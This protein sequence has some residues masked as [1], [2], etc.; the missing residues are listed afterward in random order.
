MRRKK[1]IRDYPAFVLRRHRT[2]GIDDHDQSYHIN[3]AKL[4]GAGRF[5]A[6][7]MVIDSWKKDVKD[8]DEERLKKLRERS[9]VSQGR[10]DYD[11]EGN[12]QSGDLDRRR[13]FDGVNYVQRDLPYHVYKK[14]AKEEADGYRFFGIDAK[15]VPK[16]EKGRTIYAVFVPEKDVDWINKNMVKNLHVMKLQSGDLGRGVHIAPTEEGKFSLDIFSLRRHKDTSIGKRQIFDDIDDAIKQARRTVKRSDKGGYIEIFSET[17][18]EVAR[19]VQSEFYDTTGKVVGKKIDI[20]KLSGDLRL[21]SVSTTTAESIADDNSLQVCV[22]EG[23]SVVRIVKRRNLK[24]LTNFV[25]IT[26]E[27]AHEILDKSGA[28]FYSDGSFLKIMKKG[29]GIRKRSEW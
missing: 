28:Q 17:G 24:K 1:R 9:F 13:K 26:W 29:R 19:V 12:L 11:R 18:D 22:V 7:K 6:D 21:K 23:T 14:D 5:R 3:V 4:Y 10:M 8:I 20:R 25:P 27:E 15:V 2:G 16:E